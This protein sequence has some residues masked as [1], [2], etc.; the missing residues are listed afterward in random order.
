MLRETMGKTIEHLRKGAGLTREELCQ[1][2]RLGGNNRAEDVQRLYKAENDGYTLN[3]SVIENLAELFEVDVEDIVGKQNHEELNRDGW[4]TIKEAA[5]LM[6]CSENTIYNRWQDGKLRR[7]SGHL[8]SGHRVFLYNKEDVID[9][10]IK[11]EHN[12]MKKVRKVENPQDLEESKR[13]L[14]AKRIKMMEEEFE[15]FIKELKNIK[16]SVNELSQKMDNQKRGF[17]D[18]LFSNKAC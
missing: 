1:M 3:D 15:M 11:R 10:E 12:P 18:R 16:E 8:D 17:F 7:R 4:I 6:S 2:V 9:I 13:I 14:L 5:D